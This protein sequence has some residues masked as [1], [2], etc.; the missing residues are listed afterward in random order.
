MVLPDGSGTELVQQLRA[1]RHDLPVIVMS[2]Y[3]WDADQERPQGV[4]FAQYLEKPFSP[5]QLAEALDR[6]TARPD[7]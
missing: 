1:I 5:E 6:V 4:T 7:G 3:A 2:G